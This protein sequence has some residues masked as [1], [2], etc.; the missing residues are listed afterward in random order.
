MTIK[1]STKDF[2]AQQQNEQKTTPKRKIE[3]ETEVKLDDKVLNYLYDLNLLTSTKI[4]PNNNM[5]DK[6]S[7]CACWW[8]SMTWDN[9][10]M[11]PDNRDQ[12]EIPA[13]DESPDRWFVE[14]QSA[15]TAVC[16]KC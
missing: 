4:N 10:S 9:T 5:Y 13:E 1:T 12:A 3:N 14:Y 6:F 8:K 15:V 11:E 2:L 16:L 7:A